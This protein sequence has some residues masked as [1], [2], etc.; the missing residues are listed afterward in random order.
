MD[1][2]LKGG[3]FTVAAKP[4]PVTPLVEEK[5]DPPLRKFMSRAER[6]RELNRLAHDMEMMFADKLSE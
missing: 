3:H 4:K 5:P 2:P 6:R 1:G